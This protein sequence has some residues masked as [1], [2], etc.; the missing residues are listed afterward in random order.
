MP[1]TGYTPI[2]LYGSATA[3]AVPA[4][5]N[6]TNGTGGSEIA[7][8]I[9]DGRLYYKDDNGA[10]Q[11]IGAKLNSVLAAAMSS[12]PVGSGSVVLASGV[13]GTG[14]VVLAS[15]LGAY[16][17]L[18]G[19]ATQAFDALTYAVGGAVAIKS[20]GFLS[21]T[22][23]AGTSGVRFVNQAYSVQ[24]FICDD[25]G[26]VT[27]AGNI[28]AY[29]DERVKSEWAQLPPEFLNALARVKSG[30]Y[31]RTDMSAHP[32]QTGVSA[33]DMRGVL[34]ES[35]MESADGKL[36]VAYGNAAL[37]AAVQLARKVLDLDHRLAALEQRK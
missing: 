9:T 4:A 17:A 22:N 15:A 26:N 36:S 23:S 32:R 13:T 1:A 37:V 29:S 30:T 33:Q 14:N 8:N 10:V 16:A 19:S 5:A 20:D 11:L 21:L 25:A 7:I 28:T 3:S 35:V 24:T 12:A 18:A 6:L 2:L 27:A 31:T 34:P